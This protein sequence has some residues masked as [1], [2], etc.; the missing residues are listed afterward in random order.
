MHVSVMCSKNYDYRCFSCKQKEYSTIVGFT[1]DIYEL[2]LRIKKT[3]AFVLYNI[4]AGAL[5]FLIECK[6]NCMLIEVT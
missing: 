3:C 2:I 5:L 1:P 4:R 6:T